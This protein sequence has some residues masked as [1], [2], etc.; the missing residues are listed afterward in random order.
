MPMSLAEPAMPTGEPAAARQRVVLVGLTAAK[1]LV[2]E[3]VDLVD[4]RNHRLFQP[5]LHQL[6][7]AALSP[8][9]IASP[10]RSILRA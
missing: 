6:A 9:N 10:I 8:V 1:M 4:R 2:R 5:L 3:A 7:R